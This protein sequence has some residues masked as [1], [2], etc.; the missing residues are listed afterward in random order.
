M[1]NF[2]FYIDA[3]DRVMLPAVFLEISEEFN[4]GPEILGLIAL[5]RGLASSL[6]GSIAG[7]LG[8]RYSRITITGFAAIFWGISTIIV[9]MCT[10]L[11]MLMIARAMNGLGLGLVNPL[12]RSLVA[13][14][15]PADKRGKAF[16]VVMLS[17]SVGATIGSVFATGLAASSYIA[18][19][20]GNDVA[21][22]ITL[23]LLLPFLLTLNNPNYST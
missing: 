20:P 17:G 5:C 18:G 16:G 7:P 15:T 12:I 11:E 2:I 21:S 10:S 8:N 3:V 1:L 14:I 13:D 4:C 19:V 22:L 9:G 6:V 23:D